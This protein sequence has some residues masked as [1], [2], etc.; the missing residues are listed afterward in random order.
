MAPSN[1]GARP[2]R[3][4]PDE[5]RPDGP[6]RNTA[7]NGLLDAILAVA[8]DL[9]LPV[10][11]DR[12]VAGAAQ[13]VDARYCALGVIAEH[14]GLAE[15]RHTGVDEATVAAIG[16][17]PEGK[18]ILGLLIRDPQP[19]RLRDLRDHPDSFGFPP[20]HPP[21][22]SFLG[23]PIRVRDR[24]FGNL[25]L[26]D[27]HD[28][29]EFTDHDESLVIALAAAAGV[30]IENARLHERLQE[31]AIIE[32]RERIARDLHDR[33][34][35]RIFAAGMA[36]Q[37]AE[38]LVTEPQAVQRIAGA[39]DELDATMREI[40]A[41][42]FAL[43]YRPDPALSDAVRS[44]AAEAEATLGAPVVVHLDGPVDRVVPDE[45]AE[46]MLIALG[47]A[48]TN[49]A[50]H[51]RAGRVDVVVSAGADLVLRVLDDGVGCL[52][53]GDGAPGGGSATAPGHGRGL[54]NLA[55]RAERLGGRCTLAARPEG[56][57]VLE[58][59]VPLGAL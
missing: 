53:A 31:L 13:L 35:Q 28:G 19:I 9:T 14:G 23:V 48:L 5:G 51:A 45:V 58:W 44:T 7:L 52:A 30:A 43:S 32:D 37:A 18:G 41:T 57:S 2:D 47:E 34:I 40:R 24:V 17:M 3:A 4:A 21:M 10:V 8:S 36:L 1:G 38:R 46:Q 55:Q 22:R 6:V 20:G 50:R 27:K 11:L 56:G 33:V 54:R 39:I 12:I 42:I 16:H 49:V 25:Y 29:T 15:F 26:C 59:R